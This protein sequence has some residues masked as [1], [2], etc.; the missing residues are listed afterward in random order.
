MPTSLKG[1]KGKWFYMVAQDLELPFRLSLEILYITKFCEGRAYFKA[2]ERDR[3][4]LENLKTLV[5]DIVDITG[6]DILDLVDVK[7]IG[8]TT[9]F[10]NFYC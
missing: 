10:F 1:W 7:G 4:M 3:Q 5:Y 6:D 8:G 2:L 9:S